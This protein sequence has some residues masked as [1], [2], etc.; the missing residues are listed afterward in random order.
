[1]TKEIPL[2]QGKVALVDDDDYERLSMYK[3]NAANDGYASRAPAGR[4]RPVEFM[5][6]VILNAPPDMQADHINGN[7]LDN[8]KVNL[9]LCTLTQ[10]NRNRAKWSTAT[11]S[12]YKGVSWSKQAQKWLAQITVDWRNRYLGI[13]LVEEDAAR[14]YDAAAKQYFGEF[15][16]LNFPDER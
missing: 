8:R 5:H 13:F 4:P 16:R 7:R 3:W 6:R 2:T 10:N 1:M 12:R 9:R 15:A 14:A 11:S